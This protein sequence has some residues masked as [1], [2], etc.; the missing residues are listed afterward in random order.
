MLEFG[1]QPE[2][3]AAA[4]AQLEGISGPA[5]DGESVRDLVDLFWISIDNEESLDLDQLSVA[6]E[7]RDGRVHLMVAIADVDALVKKDTPIDE[8]ARLNTTSIYTPPRVFSML[9]VKL[10]HGFTSLL[11]G[12]AKLAVVAEMVVDSE[13]HVH[14]SAVFRAR[15][16]NHAKLIY[17]DVAATLDGTRPFDSKEIETQLR[18]HV[19]ASTALREQR[20]QNGA[21]GF[22]T[23]EPKVVFRDDNAAEVKDY[24]RNKARDIIEDLMIAANGITAR[25]L[26]KGGYASIRRVVR[27]PERWDRI[28]EVAAEFGDELPRE[29]DSG[30]LEQFLKRMKRTDPLRFPDLSLAIIKLLGRGEYEVEEP[31]DD[32]FNHFGLAVRDYTHSTAPNRRYPD[33]ITQRLVKA[34]LQKKPTP[35]TRPELDEL[36]RHCTEREDQANKV[37]RRMVKAAAAIALSSRIGERF[38]GIVTGAS[39]KGTWVRILRPSIEGKV[40]HGSH[41]LDVGDRVRVKLINT[42]PE[43]GFIDFARIRR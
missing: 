24:L 21:L 36:A 18:L 2:L 5:A 42:D 25:F 37:E 27:S 19:K 29:P 22:E 34:A 41:G 9:P 30:A 13:G 11:P 7:A 12:E 10:S 33:L 14:E 1:F 40:V 28:V 23:I 16:R 43:R 38:D 35:Y 3:S 26:E 4:V 17:E 15:V 39:E 6:S 8:H 31:G 32:R 20:E